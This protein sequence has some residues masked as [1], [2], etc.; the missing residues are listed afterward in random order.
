M[1]YQ[2]L[3]QAI[4][5]FGLDRRATLAQIKTRHRQLV[6]NHHPDRGSDDDLDTIRRI[7]AA[8]ETL[9]AYCKGYRYCFTEE[10]FLEQFPEERMRRQFGW[11][12][13]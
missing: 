4:E 5:V 8:H 11:D 2:E 9:T 6:K 10:E 7:N 3:L 12:P 13:I 1:T